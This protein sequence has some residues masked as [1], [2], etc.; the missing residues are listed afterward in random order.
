VITGVVY[1][2]IGRRLDR[3]RY[4]R[5]G[6]PVDIGGR[7]LNL[8]CRGQGSPAVI[9]DSGGHTAGYSWIAIQPEGKIHSRLLV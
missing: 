5:I 4:L 3:R 1:E 7:A 2:Q 8:F 6:Q 9:F